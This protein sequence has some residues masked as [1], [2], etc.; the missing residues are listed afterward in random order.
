[1]F[2]LVIFFFPS[3]SNRSPAVCDRLDGVP[4]AKGGERQQL[5][6]HTPGEIRGCVAR[7]VAMGSGAHAIG[8]LIFTDRA[9]LPRARGGGVGHNM[10]LRQPGFEPSNL[11]PGSFFFF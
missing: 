11:P 5:S 1:M 7:L 2:R 10:K 4:G 8:S 3:S 6:P 9:G